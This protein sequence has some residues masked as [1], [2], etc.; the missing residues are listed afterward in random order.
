MGGEMS[1]CYTSDS[2]EG[3]RAVVGKVAPGS[4]MTVE[5]GGQIELSGPP[6]AGVAPAVDRS[7][8]GI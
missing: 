3:E 7:R 2:L 6:E 5:P 4:A 8:G 1:N